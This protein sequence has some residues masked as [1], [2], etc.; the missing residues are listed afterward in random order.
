[1]G[2]RTVYGG[3][4]REVKDGKVRDEV[5][6]VNEVEEVKERKLLVGADRGEVPLTE[7][8]GADRLECREDVCLLA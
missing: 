7:G 8:C 1:L 6:E 5:K 4:P 3:G 2:K